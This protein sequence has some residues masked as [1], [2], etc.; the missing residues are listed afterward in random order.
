MAGM[1]MPVSGVSAG[2]W[3]AGAEAVRA[4]RMRRGRMR[5]VRLVITLG[6]PVWVLRID[7]VGLDWRLSTKNYYLR[8]WRRGGRGWNFGG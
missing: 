3:A 5:R 6:A 7:A 2:V 8:Q 1:E 4:L